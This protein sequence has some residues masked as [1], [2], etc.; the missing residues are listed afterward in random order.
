MIVKVTS[1]TGVVK[2]G[3]YDLLKKQQPPLCKCGCGQKTKW[4]N[5]YKRFNDFVNGHN[6][7]LRPPNIN[8]PKGFIVYD[9]SGIVNKKN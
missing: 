6:S 1:R 2:I 3:K 9:E 7:K 8:A 4:C 5:T